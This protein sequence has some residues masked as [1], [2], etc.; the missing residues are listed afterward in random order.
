[1]RRALAL[2]LWTTA[3]H[4]LTDPLPTTARRF[5][6][7]SVYARWWSMTQAC[8]GIQGSLDRIVWYLVPGAATLDVAGHRWNGYFEPTYGGGRIVLAGASVMDGP[9]VRHEMLHALN[10]AGAH[11]R[12]LFLARCGGVVACEDECIRDAGPPPAPGSALR[13]VPAESLAV[14]VRVDPL[15]PSASIDQGWF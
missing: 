9:L 13:R 14:A 3:C 8:S 2:L 5:T 1:M 4:D 7:P 11:P 15:Q 10:P 12:A 6:P